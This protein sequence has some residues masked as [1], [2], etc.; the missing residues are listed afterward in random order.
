MSK[1]TPF[2]VMGAVCLIMGT[3]SA[4]F[5]SVAAYLASSGNGPNDMIGILIGFVWVMMS[6]I[7]FM[8]LQSRGQAT[9]QKTRRHAKGSQTGTTAGTQRF[10]ANLSAVVIAICGLI[11][12]F[13]GLL[14]YVY[15]VIGPVGL[16]ADAMLGL[17]LGYWG[18]LGM[19]VVHDDKDGA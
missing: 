2:S 6:V 10:N 7:I 4:I 15:N 17:F 12:G 18:W 3:V 1:A 14:L 19:D 8:L 9:S 11:L 5:I 13:L 16:A